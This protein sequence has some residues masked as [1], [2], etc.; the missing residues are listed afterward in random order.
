[1]DHYEFGIT[2]DASAVTLSSA[3]T[4][5]SNPWSIHSRDFKAFTGG[6]HADIGTQTAEGIIL[7]RDGLYEFDPQV[8]ISIRSRVDN[9]L[10]LQVVVDDSDGNNLQIFHVDSSVL[11]NT[12]VPF[13][14]PLSGLTPPFDFSK[15]DRVYLRFLWQ[16]AASAGSATYTAS[17]QVTDTSA[18][19]SFFRSRFFTLLRW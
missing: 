14:I 15:G 7:A 6:G 10:S 12:N 1:M 17:F 19:P 9:I 11:P 13:D 2:E 16:A 4:S 18:M 5:S 3:R 8:N